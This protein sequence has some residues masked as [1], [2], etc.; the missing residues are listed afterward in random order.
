MK[1]VLALIEAG[2]EWA[3]KNSIKLYYCLDPK[4][5]MASDRASEV[6][7]ENQQE[8]Y[9][10]FLNDMKMQHLLYTHLSNVPTRGNDELREEHLLRRIEKINALKFDEEQK[11]LTL[12]ALKTH[13]DLATSNK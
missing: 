12:E 1:K 3:F 13:L 4:D 6:F 9:L 2:Q 11:K 10:L 5:M 8:R 7:F